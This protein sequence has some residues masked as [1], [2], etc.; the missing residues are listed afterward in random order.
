M[1][2]QYKNPANA[3]DP[4]DMGKI[5]GKSPGGGTSNLCQYSCLKNPMDRGVSWATVHRVTKSQAGLTEPACT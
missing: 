5:S 2:Q 1:A 3:G 4:G